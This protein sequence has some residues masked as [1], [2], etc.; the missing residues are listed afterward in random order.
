VDPDR[1]AAGGVSLGGMLAATLMGVDRRVRAGFF[2]MA[3]GGLAEILF[4]STEKPVRAF[5]DRVMREHGL[6]DKDAFVAFMR[7]YTDPVDPLRFAA[8]IESDRAFLVSG[9][10]DTV[11]P[12]ERTRALWEGLGKPRW[13][14]IPV[15]HYQLLPFFWWSA[16]RAAD[17][18]REVFAGEAV[19]VTSVTVGGAPLAAPPE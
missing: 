1:I 5:R 11:I 15:G 14:K 4:D 17:H 18:L 16:A 9:R 8:A 12:P 2:V 7:P 13:I 3:G 10:F 19:P 6:A